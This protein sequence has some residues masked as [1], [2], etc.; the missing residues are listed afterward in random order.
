[1]RARKFS[2]AFEFCTKTRRF[3]KFPKWILKLKI[4]TLSQK[5]NITYLKHTQ[6]TDH[7][8]EERQV[9]NQ[10]RDD[11]DEELNCEVGDDEEEDQRIDV[12]GRD[13]GTEPLHASA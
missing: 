2:H 6:S 11:K 4:F 13:Q 7:H 1:M 10:Q 12:V 8:G 9:E 5:S 3:F